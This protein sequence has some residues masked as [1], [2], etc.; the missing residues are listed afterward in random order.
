[1]GRVLS[2]RVPAM[3]TGSADSLRR[4]ADVYPGAQNGRGT[5]ERPTSAGEF[6][7]AMSRV[8]M[9]VTIVT[10]VENES[11]HGTTVSA[12]SSLSVDPPMVL[13]SLGRDS[14]L[15]ALVRRTRRFGVSVLAV[16]QER[17]GR[18][19]AAKGPDKLS[20]VAWHI[21]RGLPRVDEAAAWLA[22]EVD[23]FVGAGDHVI[24]TGLVTHAASGS[25]DPAV[26]HRRRFRTLEVTSSA[27]R[28]GEEDTP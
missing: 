12:F 18:A 10:A 11:P 7:E 8:P 24:V 4:P 17:F 21:D 3:T 15:L 16:D 28:N 27:Q 5:S 2:S 26:Y 20:A 9:A 1:M 6:R 22:C 14:D 25:V 23:C 19:C 13:I